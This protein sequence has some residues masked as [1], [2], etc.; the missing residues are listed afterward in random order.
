MK[1]DFIEIGTSDFDT[2]IG[3]VAEY[4][5]GI[6]IEAV[7]YYYDKLP[8][9]SNVITHHLAVSDDTGTCT[10][11]YV[12]PAIVEELSRNNPSAHQWIKG[13]NTINND[14]PLLQSYLLINNLSRDIVI[15]EEVEKNTLF[16]VVRDDGVTGIYYL[17]IDTEGHDVIILHKFISDSIDYPWL[18][19]HLIQFETN[20]NI[21]SSQV[22]ELLRYMTKAGYRVVSRG[23]DT[24]VRLDP[25][26]RSRHVFNR[27]DHYYIQNY[28]SNYNPSE[29]PHLNTLKD[30]QEY[31]RLGNYTGVTYQN[32]LYSVR[33]GEMLPVPS[34]MIHLD[35]TSWI[36]I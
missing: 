26:Q 28:P 33:S 15:S 6:S 22:D 7:K 4:Q 29:P 2:E 30:A 12:D 5:N 13:C 9:V 27:F 21:K 8:V 10:I 19:P 34:E 18:L 35:I 20:S 36:F 25:R 11:S 16:N 1:V 14:H 3:K 32:G 23:E 31:C 24:I 17:K